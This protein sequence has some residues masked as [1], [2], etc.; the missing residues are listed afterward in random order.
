M[1]ST[2]KN[3]TECIAEIPLL[4]V[5]IPSFV[6]QLLDNDGGHMTAIA[7]TTDGRLPRAPSP[8]TKV[9][10]QPM[11]LTPATPGSVRGQL[12]APLR[13]FGDVNPKTTMLTAEPLA[14]ASPVQ[15]GRATFDYASLP[16]ANAEFL[17]RRAASIRQG[18][19]STMEAISEIGGSLCGAKQ[20]LGHGQFIRWRG[21]ECGFSLRTAENY[22]RASAFAADKFATVANLP[23]ATVY[24]LSAKS[25]PPEIVK[26]VLARAASG[27]RISE[28]EVIRMFANHRKRRVASK[29]NE[30]KGRRAGPPHEGASL[31]QEKANNEITKANARAIMKQFGRNGTVFLLEMRENI[32]EALSF[33]ELEINASRPDEGGRRDINSVDTE[34]LLVSAIPRKPRGESQDGNP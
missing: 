20:M 21:S 2:P 15:I 33:L 26:E 19:K 10:S 12:I 18:V 13:G 5:K 27:E 11:N 32:L 30:G 9:G 34:S 29:K 17:R 23:P 22:I 25:A 7:Q 1:H 8:P 3:L 4:R 6:R 24:R 14:T 31:A 16:P 28:G